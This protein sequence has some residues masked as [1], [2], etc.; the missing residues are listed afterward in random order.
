[1]GN[2]VKKLEADVVIAG[3]GPAGTTIAKELSKRGLLP[4]DGGSKSISTVSVKLIYSRNSAVQIDL[5][6]A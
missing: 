4:P 6:S 3:S 1:M 5:I 2:N